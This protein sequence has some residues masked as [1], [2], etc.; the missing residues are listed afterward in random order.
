V[1]GQPGVDV[2]APR[3][4]CHGQGCKIDSC[5]LSKVY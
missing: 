2:P 1:H 3:S 4:S 5:K